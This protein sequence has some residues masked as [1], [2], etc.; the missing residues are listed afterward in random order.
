MEIGFHTRDHEPLTL[1][2][3]ADLK[4]ALH[5]GRSELAFEAGRE[6]DAI[7]YPHGKV[8]ARVAEAARRAEFSHGFTTAAGSMDPNTDPLLIGRLDPSWMRSTGQ[9]ALNLVLSLLGLR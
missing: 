5:R 9:L 3:D 2:G 8:E 4:D 6:L 1:L 7:A